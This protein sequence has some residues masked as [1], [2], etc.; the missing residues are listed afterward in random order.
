MSNLGDFAQYAIQGIPL[1]CVFALLAVGLTLNYKTSGVFNLAFAAQAYAS[2]AVFYVL[3]KEHT[4]PLVPGVLVAVVVFGV[5]MALVLDR[6]IYRHQRTASPLA[7]LVTSLGLLVAIPQIVLLIIGSRSKV[8]PPPLW[9]VRRSDDF[10]WPSSGRFVLDASQIATLLATVLVVVGL[11]LFFRR[12]AVGLQMRAV[13]ESPRLLQLQGVDAG[14]VSLLSWILS[15]MLA[16]L[17]GVL[18]APLFAQVNSI[19]FFTLLVA[20]IAACVVGNLT[21]IPIAF[22]GGIGLGILQAELAGF[23]PTNSVLSTG[24]RPSLPFV[25]L[26]AL[27]FLRR[28][29]RTR[30]APV[31]P[32]G[33]VDPPPPPPAA[34]VRPR[35][36]ARATHVFGGAVIAAG[37]GLCLWVLDDYWVGLVTAGV[38]L[39]VVLLSITLTTGVGGTISLCQ[40]SF[41]AVGAFTTAQVVQKG[42]SVMVGM[43]VGALVA[44]LVGLVLGAAIGHLPGIY[45]ALATLAFAL[46]FEAVLVPLDWVSGGSIPQPVPR[47]LIAGIDFASDRAFLLLACACV[48]VAGL[49]V[50]AV[51]EGTTG[52]FL[53]AVRGSNT[54]ALHRDQPRPP[55]ARGLRRRRR[56]RRL[57]GRA[58]GQLLRGGQLQPE[59]HLL[60]QPGVGR[61]G[62]HGRRPPGPGRG[63]RRDHLLPLPRPARQAVRLAGSLPHEQPRDLGSGAVVPGV[64]RSDL[65]T[66]RGLHLVRSRRP[67]LRQA[68]GRGHRGAGIRRRRPH[69]QALRRRPRRRRADH[70]ATPRQPPV[71]CRRTGERGR[72]TVTAQPAPLLMATGVGKTYDG[73]AALIDVS[74]SVAAGEFVALIGPNGAGK[75]TLFDCLSGI[76]APDRG[77]VQFDGHDLAG[78][79]QHRRARMGLAR[80]FQRIELFPGLTVRDHLLVAVRS[81][82]YH[83][84]MF[85]DL[86]GRSRPRADELERCDVVLEQLG[87]IADA[88]RPAES[89]SLGRGRVVE[90][91]RALVCRPRLLFLD[92][93]SSGLDG[94]ETSDM[95]EVLEALQRERDTAIVLC[96]HDVAFV[97]RLATRTYVLD[98]GRII[99][100]G[101]TG[102]VMASPLVRAAYLGEGL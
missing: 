89:L 27:L 73:I 81:Q 5:A 10:L 52:R 101:P 75:T 9:P 84:A 69:R 50:I 96:E 74:V 59:L 48:A 65:V 46:M 87:L 12:G 6:L 30:G 95:A 21:S 88:D 97:E 23:L 14:R 80:T 40:A 98:T 68:P 20:A 25:V 42:A 58:R 43:A 99:A 11:W 41:A 37:L 66:G 55:G 28:S 64:L 24:L 49:V 100:E 47:P 70:R 31:D 8:N 45:A 1:G 61:P 16:S 94:S 90:L 85:R 2:A 79:A 91:A 18:I 15:S 54:G 3:R 32:M 36:M 78:I 13:V 60:L 53:D 63:H 76:Q 51:R 57:R 39:S 67:D 72:V 38:C 92:E 56:G 83:G 44:A 4:W 17:S 33:G 93:P 22:L 7:K 19:D 82:R 29:L 77:R 71:R 102:E 26:F 35:W 34:D 86:T 62:H